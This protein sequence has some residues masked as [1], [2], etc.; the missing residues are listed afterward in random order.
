M[1]KFVGLSLSHRQFQCNRQKTNN[2]LT[3]NKLHPLSLQ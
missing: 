2:K 1:T 3:N